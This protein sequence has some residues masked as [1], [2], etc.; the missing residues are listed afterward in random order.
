MEYTTKRL[1]HCDLIQV[2]GRIDSQTSQEL[3]KVFEA[4]IEE[5]RFKI[6]VDMSDVEF[7]SSAGLRLLINAQKT[8][9]RLDRGEVVLANVP[10]RIY[11]A[12][13]LA[14]FVPL[15]RIEKDV[16]EAVGSF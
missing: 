10:K 12:F 8:C 16:V 15:F 14:G 4:I 5:A 2:S 1:K 3:E 7:I 9:K 13:D 11:S 6:V